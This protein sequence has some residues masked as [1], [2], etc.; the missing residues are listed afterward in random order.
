MDAEDPER[1]P[2]LIPGKKTDSFLLREWKLVHRSDPRGKDFSLFP[3]M[4]PF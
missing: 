1:H 4:K 2:W 3:Q